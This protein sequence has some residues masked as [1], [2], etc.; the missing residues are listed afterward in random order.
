MW[1][2]IAA[3]L[4]MLGLSFLSFLAGLR[5]AAQA[6]FPA[7]SNTERTDGG[8]LWRQLL[9][10]GLYGVILA[11]LLLYV[12]RYHGTWQMARVVPLSGAIILTNWIPPAGAF[13]A[14]SVLRQ[15]AAPAWR[16]AGLA[17]LILL[18]S[19]YSLVCCFQ[20]QLP[21][22]AFAGKAPR[23][24]NQQTLVSSCGPCCAATLLR[25]HGIDA[26]EREMVRLCL[27][28]YRGSPALGL[29]RGLKLKTAGTDWDVEVVTCSVE[30]LLATRGPLLLRIQIP[31]MK[32]MSGD[33][34]GWE[35]HGYE[36]VVLLLR[37]DGQGHVRVVDPAI[38]KYAYVNWRVEDL[39]EKWSGEAL[40]LVPR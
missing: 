38:P 21:L 5:L 37:V 17:I 11:G 34:I 3:A 19:F 13:F 36:H 10:L 15:R 20:G 7:N 30:R 35:P 22:Q 2:L 23:G 16:R 24:R 1:D 14:A 33:H 31:P 40:R 6:A 4:L 8:L 28:S 9:A 18:V 27:T 25:A 29:Y 32:V 39:Y 26:T 12:F